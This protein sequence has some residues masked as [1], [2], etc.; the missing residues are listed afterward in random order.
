MAKKPDRNRF[1]DIAINRMVDEALAKKEEDFAMEH[2]DSTN[3]ELLDY[4]RQ[5]AKELNHTP[6]P[7]EIVG[8]KTIVE[9]FDGWLGAVNRAELPLC[10]T[11]NS[12]RKF[13]L[14]LDE[15]EFQKKMYR[16]KRGEKKAK[17][18]ERNKEKIQQRQERERTNNKKSDPENN[19]A[20][21]HIDN[22]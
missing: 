9:R 1:Y 18:A 13:K 21:V 12:P 17:A 3:E 8:W 7:R 16:V 14:Y 19:P 6:W 22:D 2:A 15:V 5:K 20:T 11:P 4:L 10:R